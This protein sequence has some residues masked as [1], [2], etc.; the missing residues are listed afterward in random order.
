MDRLTCIVAQGSEVS[1]AGPEILRHHPDIVLCLDPGLKR[2][3]DGGD[4][5]LDAFRQHGREDI[6]ELE[7][8]F[9]PFRGAPVGRVHF[10]FYAGLMKAT[11]RK[12]IDGEGIEV[13]L[14]KKVECLALGL[15]SCEFLGSA[16]A[17]TEAEAEPIAG[18][19]PC[20]NGG[21]FLANGGDILDPSL[22]GMNVQAVGE[23]NLRLVLNDHALRWGSGRGKFL[24]GTLHD[25]KVNLVNL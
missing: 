7:R 8:V 5:S 18:L 4:T 2:A 9:E 24:Q 11:V 19:H 3:G 22:S 16:C 14:G 25:F 1:H 13:L 10:L 15:R 21:G 20:L 12:A 23:V 6:D 17:E